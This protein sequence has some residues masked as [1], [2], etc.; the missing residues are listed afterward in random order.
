MCALALLTAV[1]LPAAAPSA[2]FE[3]HPRVSA[4]K[5]LARITDLGP[6]VVIL[7]GNE[8]SKKRAKRMAYIARR[9]YQDLDRRFI[10]TSDE[11]PRPPVDL[12]LF[13]T[14][15]AYRA[16]V[17]EVFG[18]GDHSDMGFYVPG[19]RLVVANLAKSVGNLRHELAHPLLGDDF[20]RIPSWLNEGLASLY[21]NVHQRSRTIDF[22]VNYRLAHLR[23][24]R[25]AQRL[26]T[27]RALASST[28]GDVHGPDALAYYA[29]SRY[30]LLYLDRRGKLSEFYEAMRSLPDGPDPSAQLELLERYVDYDAFLKWS[31]DLG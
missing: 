18:E 3:R 12:C 30:V 5:E 24:A 29:V 21:G 11:R 9:V 31:D 16:F 1:L 19:R 14:T 8:L 15:A 25:E 4:Q 17:M 6:T 2:E 27:L 10:D 20:P 23:Q 28:H 22:V 26:P 13:E 7:R